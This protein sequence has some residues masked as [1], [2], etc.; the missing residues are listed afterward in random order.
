[1]R[2]KKGMNGDEAEGRDEDEEEDEDGNGWQQRVMGGSKNQDVD[3]GD[4][5]R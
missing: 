5:W 3:E 2:M 1:M 4:H